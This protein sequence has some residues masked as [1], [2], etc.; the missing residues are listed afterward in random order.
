MPL[1]GQCK[2]NCVKIA[3]P[4]QFAKVEIGIAVSIVVFF[5][6]NSLGLVSMPFIDVTHGYH[7]YFTFR[8]EAAH[9]TGSLRADTDGSHYNPVARSTRPKYR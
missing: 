8:N 4:Y 7:L 5:I 1:V 6:A 9:V 2:Q 3:S